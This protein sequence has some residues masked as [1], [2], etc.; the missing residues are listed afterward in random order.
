MATE[1]IFKNYYRKL[2]ALVTGAIK[3]PVDDSSE[4]FPDKFQQ[5][6]EQDFSDSKDVDDVNVEVTLVKVKW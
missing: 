4:R 6:R 5:R 2:A 1:N 3:D